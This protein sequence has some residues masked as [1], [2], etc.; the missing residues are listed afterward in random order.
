MLLVFAIE[1]MERLSRKRCN[2]HTQDKDVKGWDIE[3]SGET[4]LQ[5]APG[6]PVM[7]R[8]VSF[9]FE[10]TFIILLEK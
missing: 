2:E 4:R 9:L 1:K 3:A 8:G 6:V 7:V 10:T 5:V